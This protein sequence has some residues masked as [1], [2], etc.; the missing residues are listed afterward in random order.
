MKAV[1]GSFEY[2]Q[3]YQDQAADTWQPSSDQPLD[4]KP[5]V[6]EHGAHNYSPYQ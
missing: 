5:M 3:T 1:F 6:T 4:R 2:S